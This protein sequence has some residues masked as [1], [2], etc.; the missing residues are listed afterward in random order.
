MSNAPRTTAGLVGDFL[1]SKAGQRFITKDLAGILQR[2]RGGLVDAVSKLKHRAAIETMVDPEDRRRTLA[3]MTAEQATAWLA[4]GGASAAAGV[5]LSAALA[6]GPA[7]AVAAGRSVRTPAGLRFG[8][9]NDGAIVIEGLVRKQLTL[10]A[11][12]ATALALLFATFPEGSLQALCASP[13]KPAFSLQIAGRGYP[14]TAEETAQL[15]DYIEQL[16]SRLMQPGAAGG[17]FPLPATSKPGTN[18]RVNR[19]ETPA[20]RVEED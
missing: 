14:L 16:P 1:A 4:D 7:P 3:F 6:T 18:N 17:M 8:V 11:V 19:I 2:D 13:L 5:V 12:D 10:P 9:W 20:D 15:V